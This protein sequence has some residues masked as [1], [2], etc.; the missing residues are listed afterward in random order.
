MKIIAVILVMLICGYSLYQ[1]NRFE[2]FSSEQDG[3]EVLMPNKPKM[4]VRSINSPEG[5]KH[6]NMY[7]VIQNDDSMFIISS[8]KNYAENDSEPVDQRLDTARDNAISVSN[9]K[10]VAEK[11]IAIA[12]YPGREIVIDTQDGGV[13]KSRVY[14]VNNQLIAMMVVSTKDKI[15]QDSF[16]IFFNSLKLKLPPNEAN[17]AKAK[18]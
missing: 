8:I 6:Y 2:L 17:N 10:L 14:A 1:E 9:G 16:N 3:F 12:G 5:I 13:I 7:Y 18:E 15:E 4:A 11:K